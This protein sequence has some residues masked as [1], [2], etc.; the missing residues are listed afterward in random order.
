MGLEQRRATRITLHLPGTATIESKGQEPRTIEVLA[1]EISDNGAYLWT[2]TLPQIGD[3][4]TLNLRCT[5]D[6]QLNATFEA[7]ATVIRV[8]DSPEGECGFGVRIEKPQSR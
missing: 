2:D 1:K 8:D 4:V 6:S 5:S 7:V 3:S